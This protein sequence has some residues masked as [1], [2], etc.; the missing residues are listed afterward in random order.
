[1]NTSLL[2]CCWPLQFSE[3]GPQ[4]LDQHRKGGVHSSSAQQRVVSREKKS[5]SCGAIVARLRAVFGIHNT[6]AACLFSPNQE[7]KEEE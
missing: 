5:R 2:D 7:E 6:K 4:Q 1:V 3:I